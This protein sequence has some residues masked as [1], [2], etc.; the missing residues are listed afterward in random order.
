MGVR[1]PRLQRARLP[2]RDD[3]RRAVRASTCDRCCSTHSAWTTPTSCAATVSRARSRPATSTGRAGCTRRGTSTSRRNRPG[4]VFSTLPDMA[5]Y[6]AAL[7]DGGRGIVKPE[8]SRRR[9]SRTIARARRIRV[10]G[11]RSSATISAATARS[12]TAVGSPASS[13]RSRSRRTTVSVSSRSRT[14]AVRPCRLAAH[15][16]LCTLLGVDRGTAACAAVAT[17]ALGRPRRLLPPRSRPAHQRARARARR[18]RRDRRAQA[19]ARA[20]RRS[21]PLPALRRG[22]PML[23]ADDDGRVYVVD[24]ERVG[25]PPLAIHVDRDAG[26]P[27]ALHCGGP[28]IGRD[29][30]IA[31]RRAAGRTRAAL[32]AVAGAAA[33]GSRRDARRCQRANAPSRISWSSASVMRSVA[34]AAVDDRAGPSTGTRTAA[35]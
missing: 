3:E 6:A 10:S 34:S 14:A 11:C 31:A 24:L 7:L 4:S 16:V 28:V 17:R 12:V 23:P 35:R 19:A 26:E 27:V 25:M 13:P 29:P 15:R 18:R 2:R 20:P 32:I 1:E 22:V 30:G 5:A 9:S 8:R 33:A 21:S